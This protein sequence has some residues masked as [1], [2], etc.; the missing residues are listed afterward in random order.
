MLFIKKVV[1]LMNKLRIGIIGN[2]F[3]G[4]ATS[5]LSNSDL[6]IKIYDKREDLC[7]PTGLQLED[8]RDREL[9]FICVP[10]PMK[11]NGECHLGM[12][13][14]VINELKQL[15]IWMPVNSIIIRSTV[16]PGFSDSM[17]C[18]FMPEFLTEKNFE[19]DFRNCEKW[20]F[21]LPDFHGNEENN[22]LFIGRIKKLIIDAKKQGSIKFSNISFVKNK[23]AEMIKY[24]RNCFLAMKVSFCNEIY[25][26][27]TEKNIDYDIVRE[28]GGLDKRIGNSHMVVPGHDGHRGYGGTCFPKDTKALLH[29]M[30]ENGIDC[31]LLCAMDERNDTIDRPE[32]DWSKN[33]GRCIINNQ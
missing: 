29:D 24:F 5:L 28:F 18:Y 27:C 16:I 20:I 21:G 25:C 22:K 23:E 11:K 2:G 32:K 6:D 15:G 3:V 10:T 4:K 33:I 17:G 7:L 30:L 12:V 9:I 31:P 13:E 26:Y 19:E 8:M 14:N 1:L